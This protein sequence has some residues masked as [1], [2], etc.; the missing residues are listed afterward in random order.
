MTIKELDEFYE[1]S[2]KMLDCSYLYSICQH[3]C[4]GMGSCKMFAEPNDKGCL[5]MRE[6]LL[7]CRNSI[8]ENLKD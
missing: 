7:E 6:H 2:Q 3:D 4:D 5:K 1:L 8:G